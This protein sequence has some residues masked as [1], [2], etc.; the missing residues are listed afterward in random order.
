MEDI[1][2]YIKLWNKC[3][4]SVGSQ[5]QI[6]KIN[7]EELPLY[8]YQ[9]IRDDSNFDRGKIKNKIKC[10]N[11]HKKRKLEDALHDF[12]ESHLSAQPLIIGN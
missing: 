7:N 4:K 8:I 10:F 11:L 3:Y 12:F 5:S 9:Q 1:E 6:V 2:P